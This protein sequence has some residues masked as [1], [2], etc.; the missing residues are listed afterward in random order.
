MLL[1]VK[2]NGWDIL[3]G[4]WIIIKYFILIWNKLDVKKLIFKDIIIFFF[5]VKF[6]LRK[7]R[8]F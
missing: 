4:C 7:I 1:F 3:W 2:C 5:V 8:L 6:I